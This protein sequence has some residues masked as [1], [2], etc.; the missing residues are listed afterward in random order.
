M[1]EKRFVDLPV[2]QCSIDLARRVLRLT[3][4]IGPAEH[5]EFVRTL[6]SA[7]LGIGNHVVAAFCRSRPDRRHNELEE[8]RVSAARVLSMLWLMDSGVD[9]KRPG[10]KEFSQLK[11]LAERIEKY[12]SNWLAELRNNGSARAGAG[13]RLG[14]L[15]ALARV[16]GGT[17]RAKPPVAPP[18]GED[19]RL[20][21]VLAEMARQGTDFDPFAGPA[22]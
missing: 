21:E 22:L 18:A 10:R 4:G 1:A 11:L 16:A 5:P 12:L 14:G 20:E 19:R 3:S 17:L 9:Q 13:G 6:E 7:V 8:A 15:D 2:W